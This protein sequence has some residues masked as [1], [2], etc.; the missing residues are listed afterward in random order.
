VISIPLQLLDLTDGSVLS[1]LVGYL[2]AGTV[3]ARV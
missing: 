1:H 3:D 2:S